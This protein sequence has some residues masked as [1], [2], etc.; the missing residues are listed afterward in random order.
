MYIFNLKSGCTGV[1]YL[2]DLAAAEVWS[3]AWSAYYTLG[4]VIDEAGIMESLSKDCPPDTSM[5]FLGVLV[6]TLNMTLSVTP[7]RL[8]ELCILLD[9]WK[10][11]LSATRK[12]LQSLIGKLSFVAACVRP[13][14]T[15]LARLFSAMKVTPDIGKHPIPDSVYKDL[16]WWSTFLPCYNGVS[17]MAMDEWSHPD[18]IFSSDACMTGCGAWLF[19]SREYFKCRFPDSIMCSTNHISQLEII[20]MMVACKVWGSRWKGKRILAKCDNEASVR[21]VN[22]GR[23][24][25][26]SFMMS[27]TR[28]IA[29]HAALKEFEF[30]VTHLEGKKNGISDILS[31][32]HDVT[33]PM[34]KFRELV[35]DE[36][37]HEIT[38]DEDMFDF[39]GLW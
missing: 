10:S 3:K 4:Q 25:G 19:S 16:N 18:E 17:M 35:G 5:Q 22:S 30:R 24:N 12:E 38:I 1:N 23:S 27:C 7:E 14:R 31:R 13:G 36:P 2:D 26:D 11:M 34:S 37:V 32:W 33:D 9:K 8:S 6:D 20:T 15:F 39:V 29:Y 21:V 28:E